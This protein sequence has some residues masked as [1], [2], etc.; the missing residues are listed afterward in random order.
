MA[1]LGPMLLLSEG[2]NW[3]AR[4]ERVI[5]ISFLTRQNLSWIENGRSI[6]RWTR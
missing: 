4:E 5:D 3:L 2:A 6:L 1:R